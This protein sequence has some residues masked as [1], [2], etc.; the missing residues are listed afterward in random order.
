MHSFVVRWYF[1][2]SRRAWVPGLQR[3]WG[4]GGGFQK[5]PCGASDVNRPG[6]KFNIDAIKDSLDTHDI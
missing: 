1:L 6:K 3:P 5:V 2:I 4:F